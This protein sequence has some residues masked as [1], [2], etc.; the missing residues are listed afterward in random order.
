MLKP[1]ILESFNRVTQKSLN[2]K[3]SKTLYHTNITPHIHFYFQ[4]MFKDYDVVYTFEQDGTIMI[5]LISLE[6]VVA[7]IIMEYKEKEFAD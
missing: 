4:T 1:I 2:E 3:D 5:K 7:V 6:N